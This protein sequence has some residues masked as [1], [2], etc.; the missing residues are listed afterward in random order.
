M[1]PMFRHPRV[2]KQSYYRYCVR[3]DP[4]RFGGR[5]T[6]AIGRAL[7][8]ELGC[9]VERPYPPLHLSPL[10]RPQTKKRYRWSDEH[11][12]S[13]ATDRYRLPVAE[14]A[15]GTEG[16]VMHH[17]VLIGNRDDMDD[18][19]RAFKKIQHLADQIP[20]APPDPGLLAPAHLIGGG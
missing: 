18:I 10:Y 13:L 15:F 8:A 12:S 19:V 5:S 20:D 14:R 16:L 3:V 9:L 7:G 6:A 17:S 11:W 1:R 2:T 4:E